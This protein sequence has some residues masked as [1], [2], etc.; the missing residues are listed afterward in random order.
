MLRT[1]R[2]LTLVM[3]LISLNVLAQESPRPAGGGL[4]EWFQQGDRNRDG[5]VTREEASRA[6]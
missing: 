2:T 4:V 6:A 1:I 3:L 5:K